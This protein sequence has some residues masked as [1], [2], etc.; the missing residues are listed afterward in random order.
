MSQRIRKTE[1]RAELAALWRDEIAPYSLYA[2]FRAIAG[3]TDL[4]NRLE[5]ELRELVGRM[6]PM[7]CSPI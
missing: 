4:P 1:N 5:R 2:F 7:R 3:A 6:M